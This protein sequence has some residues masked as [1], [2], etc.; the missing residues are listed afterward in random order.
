L[1]S[2]AVLDAGPDLALAVGG[3]VLLP[4]CRQIGRTAFTA[5]PDDQAGAP[6]AAVRDDRGPADGHYESSVG[7]DDDLAVGRVPI[8]LRLLEFFDCSATV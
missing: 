3:V 5:V 6:V 8:V 2:I 4:P 1:P 7:V